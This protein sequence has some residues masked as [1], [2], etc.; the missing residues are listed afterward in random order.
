MPAYFFCTM[1]I[2]DPET[3]RKYTALTPAIVA[4][5]GGRFLT[6]GDPITTHEG[7]AFEDRMVLLEFPNRA[8]AEAWYN[9]PGYQDASKF[10]RAASKGRMFLQEGRAD[11]AAPDANV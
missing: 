2:H 7:E 1:K 8:A 10:R 3:Y 6:R 9:D 5:H 4:R 11:T